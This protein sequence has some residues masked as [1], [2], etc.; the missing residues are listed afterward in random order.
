M[1]IS[2]VKVFPVGPFIYVKI[3]TDEGLHGIGEASLSGR[4]GAVVE[5]LEHLKPLLVGQD[6][7]RIEYL[8]QMMYRQHFFHGNGCVRAT[9]I[10]GIDLALWDIMGKIHGVPCHKLWGGPVREKPWMRPLPRPR[11]RG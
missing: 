4:S 1:K 8:W 10:S 11:P 3:L 7:T 2:D 9:A 6:P 5:T